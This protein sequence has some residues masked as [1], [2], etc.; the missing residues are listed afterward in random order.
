MRDDADA[1]I[2]APVRH[3]SYELHIGLTALAWNVW[4]GDSEALQQVATQ[5]A[6]VL[7][8]GPLPADT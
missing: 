5:L 4:A 3:H 7:E 6:V 2:D 1:W 8:G